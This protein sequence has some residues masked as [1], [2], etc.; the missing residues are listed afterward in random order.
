MSQI[1]LEATYAPE[2]VEYWVQK[3]KEAKEALIAQVRTHHPA[4]QYFYLTPLETAHKCS[5]VD[6]TSF[7]IQSEL[8]EL[9]TSLREES[10]KRQSFETDLGK[11]LGK[12]L[13]DETTLRKKFLDMNNEKQNLVMHLSRANIENVPLKQQVC[14]KSIILYEHF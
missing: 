7:T 9:I 8:R 1:T 13:E 14:F 11:M 10:T 2:L 5:K 12:V 4:G 3:Y 6:H